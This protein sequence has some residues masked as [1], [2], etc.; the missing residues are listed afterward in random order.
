MINVGSISDQTLAGIVT[1]ATHGTGMNYKVISTHV[2]SLVLLLADGTRV[3]CSR[4]E[5]ADLFTASLCGLGSTGLI[6]QIKLEVG[7]AFRLKE[8][9]ESVPFVEVVDQLDTIA[10]ASEH[11]RMW[12]FPQADVIRVSSA[13]RTQEVISLRFTS[14]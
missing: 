13:D 4:E 6:L 2:L 9:Q 3:H 1:T 8:I 11:V 7:P 14:Q 12:W 10:N 5:R